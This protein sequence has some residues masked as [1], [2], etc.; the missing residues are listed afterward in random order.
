M[1]RISL[2][3]FNSALMLFYAYVIY[4]ALKNQ[5]QIIIVKEEN[6]ELTHH[7]YEYENILIK[8]RRKNHESKTELVVARDLLNSDFKKGMKLL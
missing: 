8:Q 4:C 7:L 1:N 2:F 5:N 3:F 6:K